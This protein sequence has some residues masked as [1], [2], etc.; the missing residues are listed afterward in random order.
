MTWTA[1]AAGGAAGNTPSG[2]GPISETLDLPPGSS[3]TYTVTSAAAQSA[4]HHLAG[5]T[6]SIVR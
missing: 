4:Q 3:V 5:H 2:A 6:Q 1:T